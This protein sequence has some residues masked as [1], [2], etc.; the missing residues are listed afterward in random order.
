MVNKNSEKHIGAIFILKLKVFIKKKE[1][2]NK[3]LKIKVR[4]K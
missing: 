4:K 1:L 2:G 3:E